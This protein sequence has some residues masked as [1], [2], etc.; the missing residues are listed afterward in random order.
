MNQP[1]CQSIEET[2]QKL[3]QDLYTIEDQLQ[4]LSDEGMEQLN[5]SRYIVLQQQVDRL[6]KKKL[7]LQDALNQAM[8]DLVR[9][10]SDKANQSSQSSPNG[11]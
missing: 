4:V 11:Q 6:V 1:P 10:K 9:C 8:D 5:P 2:I 7:E 3:R